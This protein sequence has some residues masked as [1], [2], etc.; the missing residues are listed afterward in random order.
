MRKRVISWLL[1]VV[2]VVS[3]LPTSVL[4]DT[5]AA[6]QEQQ[7]QQEQIAPVDTENTVPAGNEETQEQQEPAPETPAPQMTSS[8]GADSAPTAINDADGF[9]NMV[10][11]G[12]YKL[13]ADITVTEPYAYDFS[14]TFDGDGHT[15]T[16]NIT[17]STPNV[18]LFS[19]LA[20]GAVVKNVITAGSVTATGKN[21]VG[22]IAGTADG[23][24]TIENCKNTASIK[25][26]KGAGGILG[27]SEPGSGF[28]TISS[29]AN[30]GSV[31]GTRKQVGGI[32]GNVVGTHIIRNCY[33]QGDISDGAGIL[34]RGT[35][36]VLVENCYTV[37]SV[38]TNGAIMAVSSSSYSSDEPC[39]IVNCYAPSETVTA[40]VPS[41]VTISN[42]GT[43]SSAEMKSAAFAALLGDGFM[44]KSGDYPA[45]SW[46][47]P[48][49]AVRFTIAP[50]NATLEINGGTYTGSTTVALPAADAPY[51]YTVS[52][53]GYTQ[54]TGSVT[55]TNKDNPVATPDSVTVT[56]AED[57]AQWVTVTFTV[58]PENAT[59]TLKDGETQV[60]P[61]E[62]T[63]YQLLKGHAYTYT[64]ETTEEG[65]EPAVGTVTPT[66]NSTQTVAL[67]KV[68]SI[69]LKG[70]Y[71]TEYEQR[72]ELDTSGLTVTVTYTD[73]TTRDITEGFTVTGFDSTNAMESQTLTV[74]YRGATATYTIKINEKLFPSTVFNSLKGYATVEYSHNSSYTG[75]D[76]KEF[77]DEDGTLVSNNKKTKNASV[78]I[79]ITFLED[80]K[81]SE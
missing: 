1:T 66:E 42:S 4:A 56:L 63:T 17:A 19:K 53:P 10:A 6:D 45:L 35:K 79:T 61:T 39:R 26:G 78:T 11:G 50:A 29:C 60:A 12:S 77:V 48:T 7:T 16:L 27:Y 5:L 44:V 72:D 51:S 20:G 57:A 49:A 62:G 22:G 18:G 24:V 43:K 25:G 23:N 15:V 21:N 59:L 73:G 40:L 81:T 47:T 69:T 46:E 54:Q 58:T 14:G 31:S 52:C 13:A 70:S 2:M 30:M 34:G 65:Y 41:T 55:V 32:A 8:G 67:K 3:M 36:G 28:V 71:K 37:G 64:A 80:I 76:G 33:N 68:Q 9:K 75:E 38:E 74:T